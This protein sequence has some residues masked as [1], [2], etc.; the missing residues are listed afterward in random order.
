MLKDM[1]IEASVTKLAYLMGR[2]L[3]SSALK[4]AMETNIRG[5]LTHY[6]TQNIYQPSYKKRYEQ[7]SELSRL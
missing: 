6:T 3:R 5:E 7:F 4:H 2:G 1:T